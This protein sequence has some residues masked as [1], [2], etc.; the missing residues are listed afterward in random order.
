MLTLPAQVHS[1]ASLKGK[2]RTPICVPIAWFAKMPLFPF[3]TS[4]FSEHEYDGNA[5][6]K[7]SDP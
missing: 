7:P 2:Y 5:Y 6:P 1:G 3:T 4:Y